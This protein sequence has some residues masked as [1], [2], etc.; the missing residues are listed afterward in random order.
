MLYITVF[1]VFCSLFLFLYNLSFILFNNKINTQNR[2]QHIE[3]IQEFESDEGSISTFTERAIKPLYDFFSMNI[4]KLTSEYKIEI[5]NK[6]LDKAGL[7]KKITAERW[8]LNKTLVIAS[9]SIVVSV[10]IYSIDRSFYK[11][12]FIVVFI[13]ILINMFYRFKLLKSISMKQNKIVKDLPYTLD[14][15]TVSVEAGLSFDGAIARVINNIH[16]D[17]SDEFAKTL[18]EI[19]MGIERKV[20]LKNMSDRC[21]VK[22]LSMLVTSLIQADELGVSLGKVLRIESSQLRERRKQV[23]R[24]KAMKA[25]IKMMFPL[26]LFIFP[27]IFVIILGP[28]VIQIFDVFL[29]G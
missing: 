5:L 17:L 7:S 4:K 18:K 2:I 27:A 14:L 15:I 22:E 28:A 16:G 13:I 8:I 11:T 19:R 12:F 6:S 10:L 1:I 23:A 21:E 3:N 24:E 29:T 25:P 26:I 20:G 9:V